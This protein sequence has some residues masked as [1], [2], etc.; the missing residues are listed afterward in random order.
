MRV[1]T[2]AASLTALVI[3]VIALQRSGAPRPDGAAGEHACAPA[4][5][6]PAV[7]HASPPREVPRPSPRAPVSAP[8]AAPAPEPASVP[9][10]S[11]AV[12]RRSDKAPSAA[13]VAVAAKLRVRADVL[14]DLADASGNL[15]KPLEARLLRAQARGPE[16]AARLRL[17]APRGD[18][19]ADI[20]V[21]HVLRTLR[22]ARG[23][24]PDAPPDPD[25]VAEIKQDT[26]AAIRNV[27]GPESA[28]EATR[29]LDEL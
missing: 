12:D 9:G 4:A 18:T 16:I 26:V 20:L 29:A 15:P 1:A 17:D 22:E 7:V 2:L 13:V 3:S 10:P 11:R 8:R 23:P 25:R 21:D 19:I 27:A 6:L 5:A 24:T 14:A 28:P